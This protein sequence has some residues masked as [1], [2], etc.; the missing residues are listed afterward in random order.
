MLRV[1]PGAPIGVGGVPFE[2]V[3][4]LAPAGATLLLYTVGLVEPRT[5]DVWGGIEMLRGR[6]RRTWFELSL[7]NPD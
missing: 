3:E 1:P 5:R 7:D 2:A 4:L 6:Q